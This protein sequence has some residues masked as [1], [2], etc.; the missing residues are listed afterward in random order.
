M[1]RLRYG[2]IGV[3]WM[4]LIGGGFIS[5][6]RHELTPGT[7]GDAPQEWPPQSRLPR[8]AERATLLMFVHPRCPCSRASLGE[9]AVL[10]DR[11]RTPV[12]ILVACVIPPDANPQAWENT[13]LWKLAGEI[14]RVQ[15]C[16]DGGGSE[17]DRFGARTSGQTM[18]YDVNGRLLFEGG[19]TASRGHHG[20]NAGRDALELLLQCQA[21][22]QSG[23][24]GHSGRTG[25]CVYGCPLQ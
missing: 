21:G 1:C 25:T 6:L 8:I 18:L 16:R 5:L 11:C 15:V 24:C 9:L 2:L 7:P 13:D 4:S 23:Q 10:A 3:I 14:P 17:A 19:I 22:G 12:Q 20:D